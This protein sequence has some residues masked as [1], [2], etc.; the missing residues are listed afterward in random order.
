MKFRLRTLDHTQ[1]I[2][3]E[4]ANFIKDSDGFY[5]FL[6]YG[7]LGTGKT[8]LVREILKNLGW[9]KPVKSP[10][11]SIVEEYSLPNKDVYHADLYRLKSLND[12]EMLG[13]DINYNNLGI[14]FVEWPEIIANDIEGEIIEISIEMDKEQRNLKVRTDCDNFLACINRVNI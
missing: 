6:L 5:T 9:R 11:F 10:T 2:A 1:I 12:F 3:K 7:N 8:T 13:L 14:L 4:I